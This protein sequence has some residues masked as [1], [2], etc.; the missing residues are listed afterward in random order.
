[1]SE[2]LINTCYCLRSVGCFSA[3]EAISAL[4][5]WEWH[6]SLMFFTNSAKKIYIKSY[7]DTTLQ[8]RMQNSCNGI[9]PLPSPLQICFL[10]TVAY[11]FSL[12]I[13]DATSH[14]K[15]FG[16]HMMAKLR[17]RTAKNRNFEGQTANLSGK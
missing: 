6:L 10:F 16:K 11:N 1:M 17:T 4:P 5:L 12:W 7:K 8:Q 9:Y 3:G 2:T 13:I 14:V 15:I